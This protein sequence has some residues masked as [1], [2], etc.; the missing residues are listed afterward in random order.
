MSLPLVSCCCLT[1]GRIDRLQEALAC[2]LAQDYAGPKELVIL[3]S[4]PDQTLS[5]SH[6]EVR[7]VNLPKRPPNLGATRNLAVS[8]CRGEIILPY[9]D[10]DIYLPQFIRAHEFRPEDQWVQVVPAWQS[11]GGKLKGVARGGYPIQVGFRKSAW[12]QIGGYPQKNSGEDQDFRDAL[13]KLPGRRIEGSSWQAVFGY[14]WGNGVWHISGAGEDRAGQMTGWEKSELHVKR[15]ISEGRIPRGQ[16]TLHPVSMDWQA[17]ADR[18]NTAAASDLLV[19][20][21]V[22]DRDFEQA[23]DLLRWQNELGTSRKFPLLLASNRTANLDTLEAI[24]AQSFS[25]VGKFLYEENEPPVIPGNYSSIVRRQNAGFRLVAREAAKHGLPW[26]WMESDAVP[27]KKD[28]LTTLLQAYKSAGKPFFGP[29]VAPGHINGLA[30]YPPN[31]E[32]HAPKIGEAIFKAWDIIAGPQIVPRAHRANELMPHHW[33]DTA[34]GCSVRSRPELDGLAPGKAVMFH[35]CKDGSAIRVLRSSGGAR[36]GAANLDPALKPALP[37]RPQTPRLRNLPVDSRVRKDDPTLPMN[38]S[39]HAFVQLGRYGDIINIL[40]LLK[41]RF[42]D[43]RQPADLVVA[44]QFASL[45]EG[46][47]YVKVHAFPGRFE[48]LVA[49]EHW[50]RQRFQTITTTQIYGR[51]F[52]YTPVTE[53]F[54]KDSW[55]RAGALDRWGTLPLV[56]DNRNAEREEKLWNTFDDGRPMLLVALGGHSSPFPDAAALME[57]ISARFGSSHKI[58][59]LRSVQ[60]ERLY[61]LLGLFDRAAVLLTIDSAPLHLAA[62]ST[63]PAIELLM[64][65][66][67]PWYASIPKGNS[68]LAIP[69]GQALLRWPEIE[70][71]LASGE[72]PDATHSSAPNSSP[73]IASNPTLKSARAMK[74]VLTHSE[75]TPRDP[76]TLRRYN[77]ASATRQTIASKFGNW[78]MAPFT[79]VRMARKF[80]DGNGTQLPYIKDLLNHAAGYANSQ[81]WLVLVNADIC[82]TDKVQEILLEQVR[83]NRPVAL[84]RRDVGKLSAPLTEEQIRS[85]AEYGGRDL[86]AFSKEWWQ[87]MRG[88]FPDMLLGRE[89]WDVLLGTLVQMNGG[90]TRTGGIYHERHQGVWNNPRFRETLPSQRHNRKLAENFKLKVGWIP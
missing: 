2:F 87:A 21:N 66:T 88:K 4:L 23:Q 40:P 16:I 41:K 10:D 20:L 29:Y 7:I 47:S 5:F 68:I 55:H 85:A 80:S 19:V 42:D 44:E 78:R 14:G 86:F 72:T 36:T 74:F 63:I 81:D 69:Y 77:F 75:F 59:D 9:D 22:V 89:A 51:G 49:A 37:I 38:K 82:F 8:E 45:L 57:K 54:C 84:R 71:A 1:Y 76:E 50:A 58:V 43:T 34:N 65:R 48:E 28:W 79:E 56:F 24:A 3:N 27:L 31:P 33:G 70:R 64:D 67:G 83:Q 30:I 32:W 46:T 60:A 52:K 39:R 18:L 6:P 90:D 11:H 35:R 15:G 12:E 26:L 17:Q 73:P 13:N 25:V 53:S 62:A 61:D